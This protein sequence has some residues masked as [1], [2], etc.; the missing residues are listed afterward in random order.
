MTAGRDR[1]S[2]PFPRLLVF[3]SVNGFVH[4]RK[5]GEGFFVVGANL[6]GESPTA[7]EKA[8]ALTRSPFLL[9]PV[10]VVPVSTEEVF[11]GLPGGYTGEATPSF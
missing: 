10:T 1:G 7:P 6:K 2:A 9:G 3:R 4:H 5:E 8:R 11:S